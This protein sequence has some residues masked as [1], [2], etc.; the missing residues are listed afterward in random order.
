M[1][2]GTLRLAALANLI[3]Q[4]R[5]AVADCIAAA[6]GKA[7]D[8]KVFSQLS[9]V[10]H[11]AVFHDNVDAIALFGTLVA[12]AIAASAPEAELP[13]TLIHVHGNP[14]QAGVGGTLIRTLQL[15]SPLLSKIERSYEFDQ[16]SC[17]TLF[18][19]IDAADRLTAAGVARSV[20]IVAGD[21]L[22]V[23]PGAER[24]APGCTA[25]GDAAAV[26]LLDR[27][28]GG[29][30]LG[31]AFLATVPGHAKG[32]FGNGAESAAFNACH[33]NLVLQILA[34]L[35]S[36]DQTC[37]RPILGHNVNRVSWS[38]F[39]ADSGMS[40]DRVRLDLLPHVGHCYTLDALLMLPRVLDEGGEEADLLS[41]GEGGF[42]GGCRVFLDD[43][44]AHVH[45]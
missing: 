40:P 1:T 27:R 35:G 15:R 24:Y 7:M 19:A 29:V 5:R 18:W 3:P 44:R 13:D 12:E 8:A 22:T 17:S 25:I 28:P 6:G 33:T 32:R 10:E 4:N 9:G 11:V 43:G 34:A 20:L 23:L 14:V 16:Q 30:R 21:I 26:M 45:P 41:V 37:T 2:G 36:E 42:L 31:E 38:R 39:L